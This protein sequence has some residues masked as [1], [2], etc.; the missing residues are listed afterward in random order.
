[1]SAAGM[2]DESREM[3]QEHVH[4]LEA[5]GTGQE[6]AKP[7]ESLD[8][9]GHALD[10]LREGSMECYDQQTLRYRVACVT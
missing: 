1:M 2:V 10:A 9:L 4:S 6:I 8:L 7:T 3:L 5:A